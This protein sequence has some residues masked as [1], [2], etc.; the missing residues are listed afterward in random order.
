MNLLNLKIN[1]SGFLKT[2]LFVLFLAAVSTIVIEV[3]LLGYY[4]GVAVGINRYEDQYREKTADSEGKEEDF[5]LPLPTTAPSQVP[6]PTV[7]QESASIPM[8]EWGGPELWEAV[9][10]KRVEFGVGP[11]TTRG[12][13]CTI[14]SIRL[15][16]LLEMGKLDG[17][18]GFSNLSERRQDLKWIFEK[19]TLSEFLVI[20]SSERF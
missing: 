7:I 17:H 6:T 1:C 20:K 13:L 10:N 19:Y 16:E 2:L 18:E 9:N 4:Q 3:Y 12:E 15:N 14:A 8:V 11:L 5:P